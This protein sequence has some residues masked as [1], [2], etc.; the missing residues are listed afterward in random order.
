MGILTIINA[1]HNG[2]QKEK[3]DEWKYHDEADV[4]RALAENGYYPEHF[5]KDVSVDV[6][7]ST[8]KKHP[9]YV[10]KLLGDEYMIGTVTSLLELQQ[11]PNVDEMLM[12]YVN[13]LTTI[14]S[15]CPVKTLSR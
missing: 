8:L 10:D 9:E 11:H 1:I 14:K 13:M 12:F 4:R 7:V 2:E 5:I 15:L 6:Q 3:Y